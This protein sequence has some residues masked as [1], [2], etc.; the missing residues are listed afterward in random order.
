M[1]RVMIAAALVVLG[2]TSARA[3]ADPKLQTLIEGRNQQLS[4]D[5]QRLKELDALDRE[6][7]SLNRQL[8]GVSD[9]EIEASGKLDDAIADFQAEANEVAVLID[10]AASDPDNSTNVDQ[11]TRR[12]QDLVEK[13]ALLGQTARDASAGGAQPDFG[14][15]AVFFSS[16]VLT[17]RSNAVVRIGNVSALVLGNDKAN[18]KDLAEAVRGQAADAGKINE[19]SPTAADARRRELAAQADARK[20]ER[21]QIEDRAEQQGSGAD[22]IAA[23]SERLGSDA[24]ETGDLAG[25]AAA[26]ERVQELAEGLAGA[27]QRIAELDQAEQ[28]LQDEQDAIAAR[29]EVVRDQLSAFRILEDG[30]EGLE[31]FNARSDEILKQSR[32]FLADE[33]RSL[34][35]PELI[36]EAEQN[37]VDIQAFR[38]LLEDFRNDVENSDGEIDPEFEVLALEAEVQELVDDIRDL[39]KKIDDIRKERDAIVALQGEL[40]GLIRDGAPLGDEPTAETVAAGSSSDEDDDDDGTAPK[41]GRNL[42]LDR[43]LQDGTATGFDD[44]GAD[45]AGEDGAQRI[46][47]DAAGND[48]LSL[49]QFGF[50]ADQGAT[51]D[52]TGFNATGA[53]GG[54]VCPAN[55]TAFPP[56]TPISDLASCF[57]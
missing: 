16:Q 50:D 55:S 45:A 25:D 42:N 24:G 32:D 4:A 36:E 31:K 57:F 6:Q 26:G 12:V 44:D 29:L 54:L 52:I 18:L 22:V 37:L 9:A 38:N 43:F 23:L 3:D 47:E 17:I 14:A 51:E 33:A 8:D 41:T 15:V 35:N 30:K 7:S 49:D 27:G 48:P 40:A 11:V 10:I 13:G 1:L 5:S 46:L 28:K 56:G 20:G 19:G 53:G 34:G 2:V 39:S 21:Q